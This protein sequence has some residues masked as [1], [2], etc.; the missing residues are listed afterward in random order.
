MW[1]GLLVRVLLAVA[2][3]A[4]VGLLTGHIGIA[5]ALVLAALLIRQLY[6]L[7]RVTFWLRRDRVELAPDVGGIWGDLIG[8]IVRLYRRKQY[9]KRRMRQLLRELG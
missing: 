5:V 1:L 6:M 9:H 7:Q 8:L 4:L 3:A 2:A